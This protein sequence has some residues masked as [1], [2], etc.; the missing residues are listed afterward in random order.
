[1]AKTENAPTPPKQSKFRP[2]PKLRPGGSSAALSLDFEG[3]VDLAIDPKSRPLVGRD[4]AEWHHASRLDRLQVVQ[5]LAMATPHAY[6]RITRGDGELEPL[7]FD[8]EMLLRHYMRKPRRVSQRRPIDVFEHIYGPRL[9]EFEGTP[10]HEAARVMLYS[11]FGAMLGRTVFSV[12]R[13]FKTNV[14]GQYG[15]VSGTLR[16]LL[17]Q[18]PDDPKEMR[19]ELEGLAKVTFK[20]RGYDFDAMF[21]MPSVDNPPQPRKTGPRPK[22]NQAAALSQETPEMALEKQLSAPATQAKIP[23]KVATKAA[24]KKSAAKSKGSATPPK[25][26]AL[27]RKA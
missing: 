23:A 20:N 27:S 11:R 10:S 7:P 8:I 22:V 25:K 26:K 19:D 5:M 21:P 18:L 4:I 15:G 14:S 9:R 16:R 2:P 24:A 1:M 3:P 6:R 17:D 12:Y 13:W